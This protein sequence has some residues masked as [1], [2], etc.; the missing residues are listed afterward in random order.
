MKG[1][2]MNKIQSDDIIIRKAILH[3]LDSE[4]GYLKMSNN[5]LDLGYELNDFFRNR[6][7]QIISGDDAKHGV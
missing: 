6:I 3:I 4:S 5:L 2:R 1:D 7:F